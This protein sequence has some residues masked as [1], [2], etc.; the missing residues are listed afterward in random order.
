MI[1]VL[2]KEF[3]WTYDTASVGSSSHAIGYLLCGGGC[4]HVVYGTATNTARV[5]WKAARK[6]PH[7]K[8]PNRVHW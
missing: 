1:R 5:L 3:R 8:A 4:R 7:S 6:C 2:C